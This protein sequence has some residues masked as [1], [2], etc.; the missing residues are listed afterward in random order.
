MAR[1]CGL[2]LGAGDGLELV[3]FFCR[4]ERMVLAWPAVHPEKDASLAARALCFC[5]TGEDRQ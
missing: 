2:V 1:C 4:A 5:G 3:S